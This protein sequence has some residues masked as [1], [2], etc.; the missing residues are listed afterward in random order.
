M[1][2]SPL[3]PDHQANL[4]TAPTSVSHPSI[5]KKSPLGS[6]DHHRQ[7]QH[8]Q[9]PP[10]PHSVSSPQSSPTN[11]HLHRFTT[12]QSPVSAVH[13]ANLSN[14][15]TDTPIE[16]S[17]RFSQGGKSATDSMSVDPNTVRNWPSPASASSSTS[18]QFSIDR[19]VTISGG[20]AQSPYQAQ[21]HGRHSSQAIILSAT[22]LF[23]Q[24][25][26]DPTRRASMVRA[27]PRSI[28]STS[29]SGRGTAAS[30][31]ASIVRGSSPALGNGGVRGDEPFE[32]TLLLVRPT[33]VL[34][35]DAAACQICVKSF[36]TMRRKVMLDLHPFFCAPPLHSRVFSCLLSASPLPPMTLH[37]GL[38]L[39]AT[40]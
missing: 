3:N 10:P 40:Y 27:G 17:K 29:M 14:H 30:T 23:A 20:V 18:G 4:T 39:H 19:N 15:A 11:S 32:H 33:W 9:P 36:N 12:P 26:Q 13:D 25:L 5:N 8:Q 35:Q 21:G 24:Q 2:A 16:N 7:L 31:A 6:D 28:A 38:S 37:S 22:R 1:P 34:D